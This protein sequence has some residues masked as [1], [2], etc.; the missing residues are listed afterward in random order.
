M[1]AADKIVL[2]FIVLLSMGGFPN[3]FGKE[4]ITYQSSIKRHWL[5]T[6][7]G[8]F[9]KTGIVKP[10]EILFSYHGKH[11]QS[12]DSINYI[13]EYKYIGKKG[14]NTFEL[15]YSERG[16]IVEKENKEIMKIFF[17]ENRAVNLYNFR[18]IYTNCGVEDKVYLQMEAMEDD[19]LEY[20]IILPPCLEKAKPSESLKNPQERKQKRRQR[21]GE[22][23]IFQF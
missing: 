19:N 11:K 18:S 14:E 10:G 23:P 16:T 3:F 6:L 8:Y 20:Q 13:G 21:E 4:K 17:F 7:E 9:T 22:T 12:P 15:E 5:I 2:V 1:K